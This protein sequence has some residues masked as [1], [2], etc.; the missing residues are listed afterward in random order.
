M[1][2]SRTSPPTTVRVCVCV[3]VCLRRSVSSKLP[4][5]FFF[6]KKTLGEL[7]LASPHLGTWFGLLFVMRACM[8]IAYVYVCLC[9]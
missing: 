7:L 8:W 4:I 3:C 2:T 6:A 1:S 5:V 9:R